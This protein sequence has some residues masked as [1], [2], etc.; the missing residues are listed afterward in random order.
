MVEIETTN[1]SVFEGEVCD[2]EYLAPQVFFEN[3]DEIGDEMAAQTT[4]PHELAQLVEE[5][6]ATKQD[7]QDA[8]GWN[9]DNI[10]VYEHY[11]QDDD[12]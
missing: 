4:F 10:E 9:F 12:A 7:L 1:Y 5:G 3:L 2:G 11:S 8:S 6:K